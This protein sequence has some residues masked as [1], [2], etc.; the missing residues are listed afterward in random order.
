MI[1]TRAWAFLAFAILAL[2]T[3]IAHATPEDDDKANDG[4][5]LAELSAKDPA[6]VPLFVQA[7]QARA[8][9]D[10]AAASSLY[11]QLRQADPWFS[12]AA[13]RRCGEELK[14]HHPADALTLCRDALQHQPLLAENETSLALALSADAAAP[15]AALS[16]A[17]T[18]AGRDGGL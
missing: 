13:R 16:E 2:S 11:E 10:A 1:S 3:R 14:L 6:R 8:R 9:G 15:A 4:R 7:N 5:L 17:G 18:A 12:A